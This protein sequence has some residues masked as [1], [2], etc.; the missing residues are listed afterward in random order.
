M[1]W[2]GKN[3]SLEDYCVTSQE[4]IQRTHANGC[5][6]LR[7]ILHLTL[8]LSVRAVVAIFVMFIL[9]F[10]SEFH[11]SVLSLSP[12]LPPP[13]PSPRIDGLSMLFFFA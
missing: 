13:P 3:V 5:F 12:P 4:A 11:I 7:S 6:R 2:V 10:E 9:I 1:C 8:K